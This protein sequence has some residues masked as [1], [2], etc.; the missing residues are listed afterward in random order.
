[1]HQFR[2]AWSEMFRADAAV[3][4][5]LAPDHLNWHR[6]MSSHEAAKAKIFAQQHRSDTAIGGSHDPIVMTHLQAAPSRQIT[7]GFEG[8]YHFSNGADVPRGPIISTSEMTRSPRHHQFGCCSAGDGERLCRSSIG[9]RSS[10][11]FCSSGSPFA[12]VAEVSGVRWFND[13]KRQHRTLHQRL[14]E[15]SRH[16][17][18]AAGRN[19]DLDPTPMA[20]EG[21]LA[22]SSPLAKQLLKFLMFSAEWLRS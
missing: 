18:L 16:R 2:L 14:S 12:P 15:H 20:A 13:S 3:W 7:F 19:K 10:S 17:S 4:L 21:A 6:D 8:D 9:C 22:A 11:R 5:N 1:M